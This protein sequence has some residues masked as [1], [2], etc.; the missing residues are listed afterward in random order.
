MLKEGTAILC[1]VDELIKEVK[2][3]GSLGC[4]DHTL[5]EFVISRNVGLAKSKVRTL[6]IQRAI[7]KPF[8][9]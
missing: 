1:S 7:L 4:S 5:V 2:I 9:D 8:K 3:R 6:D